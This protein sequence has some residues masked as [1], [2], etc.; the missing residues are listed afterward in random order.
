MK[1]FIFITISLLIYP[2]SIWSQVENLE[3]EG[4]ILISNSVDSVASPGTIRWTGSDF[5]GWN[6]IIWVSLTNGKSV[7]SLTDVDGNTYRTIRIGEQEWM[8]DNLASTK[9]RGGTSILH[10]PGDSL[11]A[12]APASAWC[13]YHAG[14]PCGRPGCGVSSRACR[15]RS[16]PCQPLSSSKPSRRCCP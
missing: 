3:V 14:W 2:M 5:E 12:N 11:W 15:S 7:G 1:E 9:F 16:W 4:A 10:A 6:G 13:W 8:A